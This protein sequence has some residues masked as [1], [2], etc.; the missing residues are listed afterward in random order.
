MQPAAADSRQ[1]Q[2]Q[3]RFAYNCPARGWHNAAVQSNSL[4]CLRTPAHICMV[5]SGQLAVWLAGDQ[6]SVAAA[7]HTGLASH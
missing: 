1:L 4:Q 3:Q 2:L 5:F 6:C 7:K